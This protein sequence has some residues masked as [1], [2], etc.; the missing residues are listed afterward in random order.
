MAIAIHPANR[1][2]ATITWMNINKDGDLIMGMPELRLMMP[3]LRDNMLM[4]MEVDELKEAAY[5]AQVAGNMELVQ[6]F[7]ARLDE[8]EARLS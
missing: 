2:L 3:L 5:S 7:V 1:K 6:F 4:V 8:L